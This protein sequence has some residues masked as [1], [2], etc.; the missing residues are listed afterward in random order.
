MIIPIEQVFRNVLGFTAFPD[1]AWE[2][3]KLRV[4]INRLTEASRF[5]TKEHVAAALK[6][7]SKS[8]EDWNGSHEMIDKDSILNSYPLTNIK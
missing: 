1:E 3:F 4:P 8:A 7:A 6:E 2:E 5:H